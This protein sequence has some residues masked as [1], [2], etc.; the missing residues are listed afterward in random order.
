VPET[1]LAGHRDDRGHVFDGIGHAAPAGSV[2]AT[3]TGQT[4]PLPALLAI[5][6]G[7]I[8]LFAL[9]TYVLW[10]LID[11]VRYGRPERA[12]MWCDTAAA[13]AAAALAL[14]LF[15][16]VSWWRFETAYNT[17]LTARSDPSA[18]RVALDR[19]TERPFPPTSTCHWSDGHTDHLIPQWLNPTS[20]ALL[21]LA[22]IA[23]VAAF[24]TRRVLA[25]TEV[26]A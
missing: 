26:D 7:A 16:L 25:G 15:G 4:I 20:T 2:L 11:L 6:L 12:A 17:C 8:V 22:L 13:L 1:V 3:D 10:A 19:L 5:P 24:R 9:G 14:Q 18:R 21:A 23:A